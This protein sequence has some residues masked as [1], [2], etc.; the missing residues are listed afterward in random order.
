MNRGIIISIDRI[1]FYFCCVSNITFELYELMV[2][3]C[4]HSMHVIKVLEVITAQTLNS[5]DPTHIAD[6]M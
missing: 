3:S 6:T 4:I 2:N 1:M 5:F